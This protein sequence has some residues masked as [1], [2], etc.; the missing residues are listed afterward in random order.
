MII[1]TTEKLVKHNKSKVL[2][3]INQAKK[4]KVYS[5]LELY[6]NHS[7]IAWENPL[8]KILLKNHSK[9]NI[10]QKKLKRVK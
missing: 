10:H 8:I 5:M 6:N 3:S 4:N 7:N 2:I 9:P 1:L